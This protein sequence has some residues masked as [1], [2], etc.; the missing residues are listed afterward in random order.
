MPAGIFRPEVESAG[1][2]E[3]RRQHDGLVASLAR[4]LDPKIPRIQRHKGK[5]EVLADEHLLGKGI[6]AVDSISE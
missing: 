5:V 2:L 1:V 4:Q 6:E 3:V